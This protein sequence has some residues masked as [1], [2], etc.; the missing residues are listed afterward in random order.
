M[1]KRKYLMWWDVVIISMI[2]FGFAIWNSTQVFLSTDS[3]VLEHAT[4]FT[5]WDNLFGI[6]TIV[7]E[8]SIAFVYL[9]LRKFDFSQWKYKI[10]MK[11]TVRAV[12]IF[13][14]LSVLM[15]LSSILYLGFKEATAYVGYGGIWYVLAE[16]DASLIVFSLLNGIYEEIFFLG[17]CTSVPES[18]RKAVF[19]YSL[20]IRTSFHTYQGLGSALSIG[21]V[22][23][24]VYYLLYK[25]DKN[26][27]PY[28]LSH[29]FA[30]IFGAGILILL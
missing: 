28:M 4:E 1:T 3:Q 15:D 5:K 13:L 19:F 9:K 20:I 21:L 29:S 23:G 2:L 24:S 11:D 22:I 14:L 27:Y 18:Q 26:L 12:F 7:V 25:K 17:I 6:F 16:I 8:L 30:D 10:T